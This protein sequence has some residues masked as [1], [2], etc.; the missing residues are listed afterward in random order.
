MESSSSAAVTEERRVLGCILGGAIGDALGAAIEVL[1]DA[2]IRSRFGPKGVSGYELAYGRRG[3]IT[4]DTQM[5]LFTAEGLIRANT[6][7][8]LRGICHPPSIIHHAYLRWLHTQGVA[9]LDEVDGWLVE[10]PVLHHR[11]A[12]GDTCL[13]ALQ[14]T[15]LGDF[16]EI[17]DNLSKGCGG[18]VR[19]APVGIVGPDSAFDLGLKA[20]AITHGHPSGHLSAAAFAS[21][22]ADIF[23]GCTLPTAIA[24]SRAKLEPY[25]YADEVLVALDNAVE[26]AGRQPDSVV[27]E[28]GEGWVGEEALAIYLFCALTAKDFRSGV[29]CAVNHGGDSDST[30]SITGNLLG[31]MAGIDAIPDDW[32]CEL[33]GEH[34]IRTV[35][36]DLVGH[37]L[38][39]RSAESDLA[40]YPGW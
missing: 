25:H 22:V 7:Q 35:A 29:L 32:V 10:Q 24:Q 11:R 21:I 20:A 37:F 28:L 5:T 38:E 8:A 23:D 9:C 13:S 34:V 6:R 15:K 19:V 40:R 16:P 31:A 1:S 2:E 33:E 27:S 18:V 12:P 17:A 36:E 3:A 39:G 26:L 14:A 4:D 30:G